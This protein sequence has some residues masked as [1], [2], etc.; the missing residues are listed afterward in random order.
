MEERKEHD[1]ILYKFVE[2]QNKEQGLPL[3]RTVAQN[4]YLGSKRNSTGL[5]HKSCIIQMTKRSH[6]QSTTHEKCNFE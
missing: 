6:I 4:H 1:G 2:A 3:G 5:R